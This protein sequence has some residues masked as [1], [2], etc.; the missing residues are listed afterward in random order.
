[1]VQNG[2]DAIDLVAVG[3][4]ALARKD[5]HLSFAKVANIMKSAYV[6]FYNNEGTY[7]D[8]GPYNNLIHYRGTPYDPKKIPGLTLTGFNVCNMASNVTLHWAG[9][10]WDSSHKPK[11]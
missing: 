3:D 4:I 5:Y 11:C 10:V 8:K 1:M 6:A 9:R 7:A 2:K